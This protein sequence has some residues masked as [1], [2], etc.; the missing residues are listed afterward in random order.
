[1]KGELI[2]W[3]TLM[4]TLV[5]IIYTYL[6][7]SIYNYI[8]KVTKRGKEIGDDIDFINAF[9]MVVGLNLI[10]MVVTFIILFI[11]YGGKDLVPV[12]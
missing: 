7:P 8:N 11:V 12:N 2:L 6:Y 5:T 3:Q 9:L 10:I 1:M 4:I